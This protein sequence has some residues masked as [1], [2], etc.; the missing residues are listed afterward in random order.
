MLIYE[1]NR[2]FQIIEEIHMFLVYFNL[3]WNIDNEKDFYDDSELQS[4]QSTFESTL[5]IGT[6]FK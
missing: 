3:S 4:P 6:F 2:S 5:R 1:S